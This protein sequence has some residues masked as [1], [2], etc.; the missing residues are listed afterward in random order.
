[1]GASFRNL[2]Q[3]VRLAGS[4][5]LTISLELL[6]QLEKPDGVLEREL[7]PPTLSQVKVN[8]WA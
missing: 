2:N 5:L 4:D 7:D 6:D 8:A 3:I 1:M